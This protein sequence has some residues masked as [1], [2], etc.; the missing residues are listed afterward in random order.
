[1]DALIPSPDARRGVAAAC[2]AL[3]LMLAG[4]SQPPA[5]PSPPPKPVKVEA[6]GATAREAIQDGF[7]GTLRARQR[8]DLSADAAGRLA[9]VLVDVGDKVR[10][11]QLLAKLDDAPARWRLER[12]EAEQAAAAAALAERRNSLR[13]HEALAGDK[14]IA[15]STL[16]AAQAAHRQALSSVQAAEAALAQARRDVERTRVLAP[17]D[18]EIVARLVQPHVDVAP[19]QPLLQLEAGRSLEAVVMLPDT[20]AAGLTAGTAASG[21]AGNE[22][23]ALKLERLSARSDNGSLVQAVFRVE[24]HPAVLR[25]GGVLTVALQRD[26]LADLSLPVAALM[27]DSK[28]GGRA[29]VFV[30]DTAH[31]ALKRKPVQTGTA[32]LA[33][34]RVAITQ[35]LAR[36]EQV[37]VAGTAFLSEG[38]R[39]V[40]EPAQTLL[41]GARP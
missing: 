27:P 22:R 34:G 36:G 1:M 3:T 24:G 18:G 30:L 28:G 8:A 9:A 5:E 13:N 10:A 32:L 17:F 14:I 39:A 33:G 11:G 15:P 26:V 23:V 41:Q 29:S 4:C 38:Q 2:L 40:A 31:G 6:I 37:V 21:Q 20:V 25:S 12:A 7:V 19:G 16:E 35:G